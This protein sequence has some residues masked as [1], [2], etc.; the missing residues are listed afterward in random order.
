[1]HKMKA[2]TDK[3]TLTPLPLLSCVF[4]AEDALLYINKDLKTKKTYRPCF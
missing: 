4:V 3:V 1:M 2:A